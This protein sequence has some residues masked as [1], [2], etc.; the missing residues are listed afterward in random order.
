ML[1]KCQFVAA[2]LYQPVCLSVYSAK[3][4]PANIDQLFEHT[5]FTDFTIYTPFMKE[6]NILL[7]LN[8][9][10]FSF[11]MSTSSPLSAMKLLPAVTSQTGPSRIKM[12]TMIRPFVIIVE[13]K[14]SP[15]CR[16]GFFV[17]VYESNLRVKA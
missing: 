7:M 3:V 16:L 12:M 8:M 11:N 13:G 10:H 2:C 1:K 14:L 5:V 9:S 17:N 6:D 4:L 15:K